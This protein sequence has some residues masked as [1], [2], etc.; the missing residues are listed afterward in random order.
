VRRAQHTTTKQNTIILT[1]RSVIEDIED[2][3]K[4][5]L[6]LL[7]ESYENEISDQSDSQARKIARLTSNLE[8]KFEKAKEK[9]VR[10][11]ESLIT[12]MKTEFE[13]KEKFWARR[14][15]E[16][17][18][19]AKH[20][21]EER[22]DGANSEAEQKLERARR[23][24]QLEHD[25]KLLKTNTKWQNKFDPVDL[26]LTTTLAKLMKTDQELRS[27]REC[28]AR[29][30]EELTS[31]NKERIE[32]MQTKLQEE[33]KHELEKRIDG[34][35]KEGE[36]AQLEHDENML[37]TNTR[38]QNKF[39]TV[40]QKLTAALATIMKTDQE[41]SSVRASS[42]RKLEE[43]A[44][45]HEERVSSMRAKLLEEA[46][47]ELE[48]RVDRANSEAEQK[49]ERARREAQLE[50]DDKLLK[51][52]TKWQNKFDPVDQKLTTTLAKLMKTDQELSSVKTSSAHKLEELA[53]LNEERVRSMR[54]KLE[55]SLKEEAEQKLERAR[56]EAQL[57][58]DDKLLKTNTRW[59]TKFDPVDQKLTAALAQIKKI[60]EEL[61]S[62]RASSARKLEELTCS[63]E[64][65]VGSLRAKLEGERASLME[66]FYTETNIKSRSYPLG[67]SLAKA[68]AAEN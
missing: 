67:G 5:T 52:N 47:H 62:V 63:R 11:Y 44:S 57:E 40:D 34:A 54:A 65:R 3:H 51:T 26:K 22:V 23:E 46:N 29:K 8:H 20:E 42:A 32:S 58:H 14:T 16:L 31:S 30:L 33:A 37:K 17:E 2:D 6:K 10:K 59:Q 9:S 60:D 1:G 49:L 12:R 45:S 35:R 41:L 56:R 68:S 36:E 7:K 24:A 48:E 50:H 38:W 19:E 25:D 43:L 53:S 13:K 27:V 28:S 18:E 15:E 55:A 4:K 39:D 21:L 61:C 66:D 64:E